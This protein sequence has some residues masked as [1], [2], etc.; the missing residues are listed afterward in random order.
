MSESEPHVEEPLGLACPR[1]GA[2]VERTQ[3]YCLDCGLRLPHDD[4]GAF[5]R[6]SLGLAERHPWTSGW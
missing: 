5:E 4:P 1:C 3:E 2:A 6:A